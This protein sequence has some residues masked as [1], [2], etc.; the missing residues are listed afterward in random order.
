MKMFEKMEVKPVA[1][2]KRKTPDRTTQFELCVF[3][4]SKKNDQPREASSEGK[5][6]VLQCLQ[7]RRKWRDLT[8]VDL[9]D[10]L[11]RIVGDE[12]ES[13]QIKWHKN[14]QAS[15]I[16]ATNMSRIE[17]RYKKY[18]EEMSQAPVE[19]AGCSTSSSRRASSCPVN[20]E[21]CIFCQREE[22]KTVIHNIET[23]EK[24][25]SIV[26]L[27]EKDPVMRIRL[28]GVNDLIAAEGKY[29]L[30]CLVQFE[31]KMQKHVK[32]ISDIGER[33]TV[34]ADLC[35][36]LQKG[37]A[38]GHVYDMGLLWNKYV[39]LSYEH[40]FEISQRYVT[41]R[42]SFYIDIEKRLAGKANFVRPLDVKA[43]CTSYVSWR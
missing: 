35:S 31:R 11:E 40:G 29:H 17:K 21:M 41:R 4:Q 10:R 1:V 24:S 5:D 7:K 20:W 33:D 18:M 25:R 6:R 38:K 22:S 12:W 15:F 39:D 37:L 32:S 42:K 36:D 30:K 28:S 26:S 3:C 8:N 23:L 14:C 19:T 2:L 27:S 43:S 16:S 13:S 9:L 34:M